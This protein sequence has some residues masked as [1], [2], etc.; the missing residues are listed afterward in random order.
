MPA[1]PLDQVGDADEPGD[2]VACGLLV[3]LDRCAGLLD[4]AAV[5]D[6]DPVAHGERLLLVVRDVQE[7]DAHLLLD[8]LELELHLL[9]QLQVERAER[10]VQ[11]QHLRLVDDRAGQRDPLPLAAGELRGPAAA[12][13][14]QAHHGERLVDPLAP[15]R[16]RH[17]LDAQPVLDVLGHGHV[18]E[19][20]V[21]LEHGVD[22]AV[23]RRAEGH[24]LAAQLDAP[25]VGPVEPGDQPQQGGLARAGRAEQRE[26]LPLRHGEVDAVDRVDLGVALA[27]R[28]RADGRGRLRPGRA[29]LAGRLGRPRGQEGT[30]LVG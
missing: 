17:P 13:A 6:G 18:G 14:G 4:A 9:A 24:V 15:P 10:L 2:E 28:R 16:P 1:V 7:G 30:S 22:V 8:A 21:I 12:V 5:Q 26:E 25:G 27:Q 19:Q 23:V 29:H 20:R 3:D 11:Q